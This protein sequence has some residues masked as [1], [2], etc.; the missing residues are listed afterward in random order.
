M[1][2]SEKYINQMDTNKLNN[3]E[4]SA[5]MGSVTPKNEAVGI[6]VN[7]SNTAT[8]ANNRDLQLQLH[9][10][11]SQLSRIEQQ[12]NLILNSLKK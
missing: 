6:R 12:N 5:L 11:R 10:I 4:N 9:L 3:E 2:K 1:N 7:S 8:P